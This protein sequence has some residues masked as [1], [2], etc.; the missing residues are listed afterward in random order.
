MICA[1][2]PVT[3]MRASAR[4][5]GASD[6]L[7]CLALGSGGDRA[8]VHHDHVNQPRARTWLR[9]IS[10]LEAV[11]PAAEGDDLQVRSCVR[12]HFGIQVS[13]ETVQCGPGHQ[14]GRPRI[15]DDPQRAAVHR[16]LR[17]ALRQ[18]A[19]DGGDQGRAPPLPHAAV[20]PAPRAPTHAQVIGYHAPDHAYVGAL[21]E[22]PGDA[23]LRDP[24]S[25]SGTLSASS[26]RNTAWGLP[27]LNAT[28]WCNGPR[29]IDV[30]SVGGLLSGI[31]SQPK[32]GTPMSTV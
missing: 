15:P 25:A 27:M 30:G 32:R 22:Q 17:R 23:R 11:Q 7:A 3:T 24:S 28:G 29:E 4:A 9:M 19:A 16:N 6:G 21:G 8:G 31:S 20:S 14:D 12:E 2:Q 26:T 1:L 10:D 13:P 18:A 5:P